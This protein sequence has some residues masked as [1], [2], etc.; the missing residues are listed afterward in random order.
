[1][2][3]LATES[4]ETAVPRVRRA[5]LRRRANHAA[6]VVLGLALLLLATLLIATLAG[7]SALI[8][9][10]GS[11]SPAI[12]AGDMVLAESVPAVVLRRGDIVTFSDRALGGRLVTHRVVAIRRVGA[13]MAFLTRGDAN[14]V[15][16]SWTLPAGASL[17]RFVLRVGGLGRATAW[18]SDGWVRTIVLSLAAGVLGTALLRRIW[19]A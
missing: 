17:D 6:S 16:E 18:M 1:M 4:R 8:D 2:S 12:R 7:Y 11:M 10:S 9:Q 19:S 14:P 15:A 3:A 13:R 5:G